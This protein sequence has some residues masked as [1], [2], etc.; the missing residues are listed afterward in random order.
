[1]NNHREEAVAE[2]ITNWLDEKRPDIVLPLH[3]NKVQKRV[4]I[5]EDMGEMRSMF[6]SLITSLGYSN[7]DV[8]SSGQA[9]IKR[10]LTKRYDIVLSDYNLSGPIDGQQILEITRKTYSLDHSTIFIMITADTNYESVVRALEYQPD[11]YLVKPFTPATFQRR[12]EK[13]LQQ[14]LVFNEIDKLRQ[15]ENY[16][17]ME[18]QAKNIMAQYPHFRSLCLKIIGESLYARQQYKAAKSHYMLVI[19]QHKNFAWAHHGVATCELA[20]GNVVA[21]INS[22]TDTIQLSRHFLSA[23]DLLADAQEKLGNLAGAQEAMHAVLEVSPRSIERSERLGKISYELND[24]QSAEKAFSRIIRLTKDTQKEKI[25]HYYGHLQAI[26]NIIACGDSSPKLTEKFKRS[27]IRLRT[28]GKDNPIVVSN[29]FR[30]EVQ[31]YLCR[32]HQE[33]A[34]KSWKQWNHLIKKG[35]AS[36]IKD[37]QIKVIK[38]HLGLL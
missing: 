30:A 1:M 21:S 26:T 10:V 17:Q 18:V 4:L 2:S 25:N 28:L 27:L 35:H 11:G 16:K 8:E 6:K 7:I 13:I 33:E 15:K 20:L 9:A 31:Q 32:G 3:N 38:K 34:I 12:F 5:I 19:K 37:T 36:P 23:Y 22:L 24:W 29:S 14:K